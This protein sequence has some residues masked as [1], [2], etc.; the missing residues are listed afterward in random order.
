MDNNNMPKNKLE[1][2]LVFELEFELDLELPSINLEKRPSM[3]S[4]LQKMNQFSD[5]KEKLQLIKS[6]I[7]RQ[8]FYQQQRR[9]RIV[10]KLQ[11]TNQLIKAIPLWVKNIAGN[12]DN[13][14]SK[15]TVD[16]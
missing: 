9:N 15:L 10:N 14:M 12:I 6:I 16:Y 5:A 3:P 2:D 13:G 7:D 4:T 8:N 1:S 11:T